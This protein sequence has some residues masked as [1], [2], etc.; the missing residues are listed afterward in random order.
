MTTA[1]VHAAADIHCT[2]FSIN[3]TLTVSYSGHLVPVF[4]FVW[5]FGACVLDQSLQGNCHLVSIATNNVATIFN[6]NNGKLAVINQ[7]KI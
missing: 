3:E 5:N 7:S 2:D 4:C 6:S 1:C